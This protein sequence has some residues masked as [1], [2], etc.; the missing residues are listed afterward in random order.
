MSPAELRALVPSWGIHLA[1]ERKSPDTVATYMKGLLPYLAWCEAGDWDPLARASLK[2]WMAE[3]LASGRS[4]STTRTRMMPVR[5]FAGW[6]VDEGEIPTNPFLEMVAPQ[7]DETVVPVLDEDGLR[8]LFAA[9]AAPAGERVGLSSL[10]HRRD[11]A[12]MRLMA[13]TGMR[14]GECLRLELTDVDV[15]KQQGVIRRGKGGKGR[16][17]SFGVD[18]AKAIDRYVRVRRLH[19][20]ADTAALW[21]GDRGRGFAYGG[22][23][24]ALTTRAEAAGI[25]GF[26]PHMLRHTQADRWL[27]AGGSETGLMANNGWSSPAML[28]RYGKANRE[29]RAME[30]ARRL[31]LGE[32]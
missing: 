8:A 19:R 31:N 14:A 2:T 20:M 23:Y 10:R 13:E 29:R 26:H 27:A 6:L 1:S 16:T 11:E 18:T 7:L 25:V 28:Q 22:L 9:C 30:E 15:V 5:Y 24:W 21:L 12:I 32:L 4:A 17:F 3:L